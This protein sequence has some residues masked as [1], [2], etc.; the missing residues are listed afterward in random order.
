MLN[1]QQQQ[2]NK[3]MKEKY[4]KKNKTNKQTSY[5]V[6]VNV[7]IKSKRINKNNNNVIGQKI[8]I[9]L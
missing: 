8:R 9:I 7:M 6:A 5:F 2:H 4:T 3:Y 1:F